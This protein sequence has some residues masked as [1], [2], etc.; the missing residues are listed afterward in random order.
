MLS[1]VDKCHKSTKAQARPT[2]MR[3]S[4][5]SGTGKSNL[6]ELYSKKYPVINDIN[7]TIKPILYSRIPCPAYIGGL[8]PQL[9]YD[10]G[11]PLYNK[12]RT[13]SLQT[14]RLYNLLKTCKVELIFFDEVQSSLN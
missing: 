5:L 10:L 7:G 11:D 1:L 13:I 14:K 12:S 9:L 2:C 3:V 4:R 8:H 6:Y